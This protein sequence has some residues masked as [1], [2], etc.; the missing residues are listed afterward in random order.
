MTRVDNVLSLIGNTPLVKIRKLNPNPKVEIYAKLESFNPGGSIKDRVALAMIERAEKSGELTKDKIVIEATSGNTGIGLAMV[1]AIKGYKL[2]LIMPESASEE[3]KRIMQAYG[4]EIFLTPGHLGTDGAIEEAYRLAREYPDK[5]VLMDQFNN[6]ASIEAHYLGTALEIWKQ[7][8]GKV[9][10]IISAL[11]TTGT[12]MGIA[13]RFRELNPN[14]KVIGVEPYIGHKIQGL[15]NMQES[16]PPG[17]FDKNLL[18]KII[19]VEDEEAFYFSRELAKKEGIFVGMSSGAAFAG[20]LKIV[21][22]LKEGLVVVIFPDGGERYLSTPLFQPIKKQD[23]KLF[24]L[25][26]KQKRALEIEKEKIVI[27]APGPSCDEIYSLDQIRKLVFVDLLASYLKYKKID[28]EA[29]VG[30]PDWDDK[31]IEFAQRKRLSLGEFSQY[32]LSEIKKVCE[33]LKLTHI[34]LSLASSHKDFMLKIC[35]KLINKGMAYEK[36][37]SVYFDVLRDENYGK[38]LKPDFSKLD[39]ITKSDYEFYLKEHPRDFTLLKRASLMNLKEG[40]FWPTKWGNVRPSWYLQMASCVEEDISCLSIVITDPSQCFPHVENLNAIW[41]KISNSSFKIQVWMLVQPVIFSKE[42]MDLKEVIERLKD[43]YPIRLWLLSNHYKK[44]LVCSLENLNMWLK[45]HKKIQQTIC[46]V[47]IA[48]ESNLLGEEDREVKQLLFDLRKGFFENM[49]DDLSLHKFW[50]YLFNFCKKIN[51]KFYK[52]QLSSKDA[53]EILN[54]IKV[55]DDVLRFIDYS[56]LP[57]SLNEMDEDIKEMVMLR[58][59]AKQKKEFSK[60]DQ[61]RKELKDKGFSVEDTPY[62]PMVRKIQ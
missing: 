3:R 7:T 13:K 48:S 20:A 33:H 32:L 37:R 21:R 15:K 29:V 39:I 50:P 34:N 18:D 5:Y 44:H 24:D 55:I 62:G 30:I 36:L 31:A 38:I 56:N 49:E 22:E 43:F 59:V 40:Y 42:E 53:K 23:V 27:F 41:T 47:K 26:T 17:I 28:V 11:G 52:K 4:A 60:A 12:A 25:A 45:N 8:D 51:Q 10:H 35:E 46:N 61:L 54:K 6:P 2:M 57:I 14:V 16:Y 19:R 1:C 58:E 9:T